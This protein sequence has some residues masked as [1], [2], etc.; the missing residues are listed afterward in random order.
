MGEKRK[1]GRR[2]LADV[3]AAEPERVWAPELEPEAPGF[4]QTIL[5]HWRSSRRRSSGRWE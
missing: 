5:Q 3:N 4:E 1:A 2:R